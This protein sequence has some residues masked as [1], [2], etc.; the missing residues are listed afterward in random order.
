MGAQRP[1]MRKIWIFLAR[2]LEN[3]NLRPDSTVC[4]R[5]VG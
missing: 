3:C 1:E 5:G 4:S 2:S